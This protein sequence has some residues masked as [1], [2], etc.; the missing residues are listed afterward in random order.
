MEIETDMKT[1]IELEIQSVEPKHHERVLTPNTRENDWWGES[2]YWDTY[3]VKFTN[4]AKKEFDNIT[5]IKVV[6]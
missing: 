1:K 3:I 2:Q 4:G 5:D 6:R